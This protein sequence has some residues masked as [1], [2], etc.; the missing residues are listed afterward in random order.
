[1]AADLHEQMILQ[2]I[3]CAIAHYWSRGAAV[4]L[5]DIPPSESAYE[6]FTP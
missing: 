1:V 3:T 6:A 5:A 4:L 2:R